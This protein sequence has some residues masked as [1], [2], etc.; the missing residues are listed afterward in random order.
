MSSGMRRAGG[1]RPQPRADASP[2]G[3]APALSGAQRPPCRCQ[4]RAEQPTAQKLVE[5]GLHFGAVSDVTLDMV[6]ARTRALHAQALGIVAGPAVHL[7]VGDL[8]MKLHGNRG[9]TVAESL[10]WEGTR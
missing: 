4:E 7:R 3:S 1:A 5:P 2:Q 9:R 6:L 10:V 8:G